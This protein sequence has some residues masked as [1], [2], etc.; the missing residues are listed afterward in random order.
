MCK[1]S[2]VP[3][4]QLLVSRDGLHCVE[5]DA[6]AVLASGQ[7]LFLLWVGWIHIT[8]PVALLFIQAIYEVMKLFVCINLKKAAKKQGFSDLTQMIGNN[9][10]ISHYLYS[11]PHSD[12]HLPL[13]QTD[14]QVGDTKATIS[15]KSHMADSV[16]T[17]PQILTLSC[18]ICMSSLPHSYT[19]T[20]PRLNSW[21]YEVEQIVWG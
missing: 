2:A 16:S 18:W 5:I 20:H 12:L 11:V 6:H 8:H 3:H 19:H 17:P 14:R 4:Q 13:R 9:Y 1:V 10:F 15:Y 21:A 7:V